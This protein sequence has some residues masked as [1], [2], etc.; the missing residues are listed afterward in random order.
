MCCRTI[1]RVQR[2][3][4][5]TR[6]TRD[7]AEVVAGVYEFFQMRIDALV[8]GGVRRDQLVLDP[9]MG[10]FL[11]SAPE[12]SLAVLVEVEGLKRRFDLPILISVSRKSF[13]GRL[14]G[15]EVQ[16]R[17]AATLA[18]EIFAAQR[19]ADFIRTHDVRALSDAL[20]LRAAL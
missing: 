20:S 1:G 4:P 3:G 5:A 15:R 8:A 6:L 2:Q 14:T 16:S 9:G 10:F 7:V 11:G 17:G 19:G 18:A 13:L 12:P